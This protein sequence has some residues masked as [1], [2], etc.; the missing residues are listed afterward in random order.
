MAWVLALFGIACYAFAGWMAV[1]GHLV[2]DI[3][4]GI[5]ATCIVGGTAILGMAYV[6]LSIDDL[7]R[8]R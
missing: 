7:R 1:T 6:L 2:S 5:L 4:I 3:Q 8:G